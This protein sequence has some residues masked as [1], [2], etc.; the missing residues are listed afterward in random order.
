MNIGGIDLNNML[1]ALYPMEHESQKWTRR[2]FYWIIS[3]AMT[4]AWQLYKTDSKMMLGT[5]AATTDL[6][7]F[8]LQVSQFLC[9]VNKPIATSRGHSRASS[10]RPPCCH[11]DWEDDQLISQ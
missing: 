9:L 4:N 11:G 8:S 7:R 5:S 10:P 3:T 1:V 6:L 2:I